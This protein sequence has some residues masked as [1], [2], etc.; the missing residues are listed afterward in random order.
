MPASTTK[1]P[2]GVERNFLTGQIQP[3]S[4]RVFSGMT[5]NKQQARSTGTRILEVRGRGSDFPLY[6]WIEL[7]SGEEKDFTACTK[8]DLN[9]ALHWTSAMSLNIPQIYSMI[10]SYSTSVDLAPS[11]APSRAP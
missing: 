9:N 3:N 5:I 7:K 11:M 4:G 10:G 2:K 6:V 1:L 8:K